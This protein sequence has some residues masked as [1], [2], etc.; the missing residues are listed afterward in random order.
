MSS[1]GPVGTRRN[2]TLHTAARMSPN[3]T[4]PRENFDAAKNSRIAKRYTTPATVKEA[5]KVDPPRS[6]KLREQM[7]N[8]AYNAT[9]S[10]QTLHAGV[11]FIITVFLLWS[12]QESPL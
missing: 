5:M 10:T 11:I 3:T 1:S 7:V 6:P 4:T 12:G 9:P 8:A 2:S